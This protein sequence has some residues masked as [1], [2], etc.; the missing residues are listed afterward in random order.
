M[1]DDN[2]ALQALAIRFETDE[3][4]RKPEEKIGAH[5]FCHAQLCNGI[6]GRTQGST[7]TWLPDSQP[8]FP[9][10]ADDQVGLVICMLT[11]L[12]G[13]AHVL[14]KFGAAGDTQLRQHLMKVRALRGPS[15]TKD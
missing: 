1:L 14:R 9:L 3:G 12:Y 15:T 10:D 11:A 13:G 7:P 2:S 4:G 8:S 6:N 5:D